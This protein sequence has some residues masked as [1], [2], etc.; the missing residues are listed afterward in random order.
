MFMLIM[1]FSRVTRIWKM[2]GGLFVSCGIFIASGLKITLLKS[3][4]IGVGMPF[5]QVEVLARS[6]GCL[7]SE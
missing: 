4:L 3:K 5:L 6:V 2:L 1:W 7:G